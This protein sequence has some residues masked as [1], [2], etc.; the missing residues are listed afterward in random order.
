M[1]G[2]VKHFN[3][4]LTVLQYHSVLIVDQD[5]RERVCDPVK[6]FNNDFTVMQY[7]SLFIVE[8]HEK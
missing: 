8:N 3:N 7:S 4:D 5:E 6:H 2:A 1:C